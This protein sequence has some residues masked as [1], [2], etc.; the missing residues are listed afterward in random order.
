MIFHPTT[1][2][3]F[4]NDVSNGGDP[5]NVFVDFNAGTN[6]GGSEASPFNNLADA[7]SFAN[8]DAT[9]NIE[10][11]SSSETFTG[12]SVINQDVTLLNNNPGGGSAFVGSP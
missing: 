5:D 12:G 2:T 4:F 6:G 11:G 10:P 1:V 3:W 8:P 7:L 9:I